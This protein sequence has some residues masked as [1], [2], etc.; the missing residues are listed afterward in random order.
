MNIHSNAVR[1]SK[2]GVRLTRALRQRMENIL[3]DMLERFKAA[4]PV[5]SRTCWK[6]AM[7]SRPEV[8]AQALCI[9]LGIEDTRYAIVE[10]TVHGK[11]G[12]APRVSCFDHVTVVLD[13]GGQTYSI[14]GSGLQACER[15]IS[16]LTSPAGTRTTFEVREVLSERSMLAAHRKACIGY[17]A[18][19]KLPVDDSLLKAWTASLT[20]AY[21]QALDASCGN[22]RI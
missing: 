1:G 7:S 8:F 13:R 21:N 22:I 4:N 14:D 15:W 2:L 19:R 16:D 5:G 10:R 3:L 18:T 9:A 11:P 20:D 6:H 17:W 12:S